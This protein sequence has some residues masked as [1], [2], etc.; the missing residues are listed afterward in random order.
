MT[1][2]K[3]NIRFAPIMSTQVDEAAEHFWAARF[4]FFG[5]MTWKTSSASPFGILYE[6]P[7]DK[8][9]ALYDERLEVVKGADV[10]E[11]TKTDQL[12]LGGPGSSDPNRM[13]PEPERNQ[14]FNVNLNING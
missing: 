1:K 2:G 9:S 14:L 4:L 13:A 5:Q 11:S 12:A 10:G 6:N 3:P 8:W 7:F